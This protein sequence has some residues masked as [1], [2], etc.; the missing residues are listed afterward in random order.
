M[1][2]DSAELKHCVA[3][4]FV[5]KLTADQKQQW[6]DICKELL[7]VAN[8]APFL[9]TIKTGDKSW[10]YGYNTENK[11]KILPREKSNLIKTKKKQAR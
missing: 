2:T 3:I 4:K 7:Q 9:S 1:P 6:V 11:A 8:D 5:L 10:L